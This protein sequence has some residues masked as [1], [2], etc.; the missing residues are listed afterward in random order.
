MLDLIRA[1]GKFP[2][3]EGKNWDESEFDWKRTILN[4]RKYVSKKEDDIF[5]TNK[6]INNEIDTVRKDCKGVVS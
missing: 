2:M 4:F 1:T 6:E 3:L 5:N